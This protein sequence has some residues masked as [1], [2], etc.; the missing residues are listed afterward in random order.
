M[1]Q[2]T[3]L[4]DTLLRIISLV[5]THHFTSHHFTYA[6]SNPTEI[7]L[8]VT[9]FLTLFLKV[10]N[11]HGGDASQPAGNWFQFWIPKIK[12]ESQ[13]G[14]KLQVNGDTGRGER[15]SSSQC[16]ASEDCNAVPLPCMC[17]DTTTNIFNTNVGDQLHAPI[18]AR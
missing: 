8:L 1:K 5:Y 17:V 16:D 9:V 15:P 13:D 6:L 12:V 11:E 18:A 14:R 10:L 3:S 7:H 4:H 2:S